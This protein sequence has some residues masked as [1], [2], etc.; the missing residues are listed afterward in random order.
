MIGINRAVITLL[1]SN[2]EFNDFI[3][4]QELHQRKVLDVFQNY[5]AIVRV[6]QLPLGHEYRELQK[7]NQVP[8]ILESIGKDKIEGKR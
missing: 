1:I 3:F 6:A 4:R 7:I 2:E 5:M 8:E